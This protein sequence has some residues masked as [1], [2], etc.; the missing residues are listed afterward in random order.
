[1]SHGQYSGGGVKPCFVL[2]RV[3]ELFLHSTAKARSWSLQTYLKNPCWT[4]HLGT[5]WQQK[6]EGFIHCSLNSSTV[7]RWN[8]PSTA[9]LKQSP[10]KWLPAWPAPPFP[11][12][13]ATA[14]LWH[15]GRG[16][17]YGFPHFSIC[18]SGT[19]LQWVTW[20]LRVHLL[21]CLTLLL[22]ACKCQQLPGCWVCIL[23]SLKCTVPTGADL[24]GQAHSHAV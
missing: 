11:N 18:Q 17:W 10:T 24:V 5:L 12:Y 21:S 20:T 13:E 4:R 7:Q 23:F 3:R 2:N 6:T 14:A 22:F 16:G 8:N 1:M 9:N 15:T 19:A